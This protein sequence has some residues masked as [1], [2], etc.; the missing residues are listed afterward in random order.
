M[1]ED[2]VLILPISDL[3]TFKGIIGKVESTVQ[4]IWEELRLVASKFSVSFSK[5]GMDTALR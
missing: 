5:P 4:L 1:T 2:E 3:G